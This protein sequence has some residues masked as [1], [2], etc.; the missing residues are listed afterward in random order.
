MSTEKSLA[1]RQTA[2]APGK[3]EGITE[4]KI[5]T[6]GGPKDLKKI[7]LPEGEQ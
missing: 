2:V 6:G 5:L 4:G 3:T 1:P 7:L